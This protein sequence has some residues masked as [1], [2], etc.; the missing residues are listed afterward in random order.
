[1]RREH[2][3][4]YGNAWH[5]AG[6]RHGRGGNARRIAVGLLMGE[7]APPMPSRKNADASDQYTR[8]VGLHTRAIQTG[9]ALPCSYQSRKGRENG[10]WA[11]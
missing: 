9:R 6:Q 4:E 5:D 1:M 2:D 3:G 10:D 8:P 7:L 11:S